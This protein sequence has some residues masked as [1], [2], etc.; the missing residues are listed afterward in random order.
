MLPKIMRSV[1]VLIAVAAFAVFVTAQDQPAPAPGQ[2]GHTMGGVERPM[3][4]PGGPMQEMSKEEARKMCMDNMKNMGMSDAMMMRHR[5]LTGA[6]LANDD[7]AAVLAVRDELKLTDD[8]AAKIATIS[9]KARQDTMAV[10]TPEQ[11][12]TIESLAGT[13]ATMMDMSMDMHRMTAGS[14][15]GMMLC[16][17]MG[18]H[19]TGQG[20]MRGMQRQGMMQGGMMREGTMQPAPDTRKPAPNEKEK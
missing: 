18:M 17:M 11:K 7:P 15:K 20:G 3:P 4:G 13:P 1:S 8:Q 6:A 5:M 10:L 14:G 2:P 19:G 12:K 9:E 16:P